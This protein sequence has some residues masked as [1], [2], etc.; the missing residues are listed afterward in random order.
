MIHK[1]LVTWISG[2]TEIAG[3]SRSRLLRLLRR[4][5]FSGQRKK[6]E[7]LPL[8]AADCA[9]PRPLTKIQDEENITVHRPGRSTYPEEKSVLISGTTPVLLIKIVSLI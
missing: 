3:T 4:S 6:P 7:L 9:S 2:D 8:N 5:D 1:S